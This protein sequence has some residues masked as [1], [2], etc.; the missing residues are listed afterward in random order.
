MGEVIR[1]YQGRLLGAGRRNGGSIAKF[2]GEGSPVPIIGA[3]VI[4]L[5]D[6]T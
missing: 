1:A 6:A 4:I 3:I 2:M 5:D